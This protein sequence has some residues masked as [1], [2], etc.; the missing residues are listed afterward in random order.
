MCGV[1]CLLCMCVVTWICGDMCVWD[2]LCVCLLR[3]CVY[4]YI[5][6]AV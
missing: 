2:A 3:V 6:V 5:Y 4:I 1:M